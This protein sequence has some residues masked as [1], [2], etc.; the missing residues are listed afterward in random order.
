MLPSF[1]VM[2]CLAYDTLVELEAFPEVTPPPLKGALWILGKKYSL[3]RG[4]QVPSQALESS[5]LELAYDLLYLFSYPCDGCSSVAISS[6]PADKGD[7]TDDIRS[8][9]WCSYR[10]NF[11]AIS[12]SSG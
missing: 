12:K 2:D 10:K 5:C 1:P 4:Q 11:R 7:M 6:P 3:P 9:L 8:R